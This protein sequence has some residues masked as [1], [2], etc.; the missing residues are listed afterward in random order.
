MNRSCELQA[1][2]VSTDKVVVDSISSCLNEWGITA[3]VHQE[4]S[5]AIQTLAGQKTDAFFV[6]RELDPEF[7]VLESMRSSPSSHGA[8]AFAILPQRH[9]ARGAFRVAD[10]LMDKPL[11]TTRLSRALRAAY[12]IMLKERMRYFRCSL[13][14]EATLVDSTH[15]RFLTQISNISQA[16]MALECAAPLLAREVVQLQFCLPGDR[17]RLSCKA[18]IIWTADKGK[19]GL[20][21]R[22][23]ADDD[24]A[25]LT[26][27]IESAFLREWQPRLPMA[28]TQRFADATA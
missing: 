6:D 25:R 10:F 20:A 21:F 8:V 22:H 11:V 2:V 17:R 13:E 23:I 1:V 5:S 24:K 12:G 19:A 14:A 4:T 16:G 9:S 18:Q 7:T 3:A 27:W 15:R 26:E 28:T